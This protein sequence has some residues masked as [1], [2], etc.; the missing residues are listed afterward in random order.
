VEEPG[1]G[2]ETGTNKYATNHGHP[3]AF[4]NQDQNGG[5]T[6]RKSHG[7]MRTDNQGYTTAMDH[8]HEGGLTEHSLRAGPVRNN[9]S[10]MVPPASINTLQ[11]QPLDQ[12]FHGSAGNTWPPTSGLEY[13]K[14]GHEKPLGGPPAG[15]HYAPG[16]MNTYCPNSAS[17][18]RS[19]DA[20]KGSRLLL[21]EKYDGTTPVQTFCSH[22]ESCALYNRWDERDKLAY[23]RWCLTG[24]AAQI[25]WDSPSE[26]CN[27]RELV[28]KVQGR[29]GNTGLEELGRTELRCRRR[30]RGE[31]LQ[32]LYQ[33]IRAIMAK[34][35]PGHTDGLGETIAKDA[36]LVSLDDAKL[37]LRVREWEPADLDAALRIAMR[38]EA[39]EQVVETQTT[40]PR[41]NRQV[42]NTSIS[43]PTDRR[44]GDLEKQINELRKKLDEKDK[45][46]GRNRA[47]ELARDRD[48]FQRMLLSA[49]M[50]GTAPQNTPV[51]MTNSINTT[52][53][54][55]AYATNTTPVSMAYATNTIPAS[56]SYPVH[57]APAPM[58]FQTNTAPA[59]SWSGPSGNQGRSPGNNNG[60]R[61]GIICYYCHQQAN[62][63]ARNCPHRGIRRENGPPTP[64]MNIPVITGQPAPMIAPVG[65]MGPP[66]THM[67][68]T[69]RALNSTD[70]LGKVYIKAKVNGIEYYCLLDTGCDVSVFP[71][72]TVAESEI[73]TTNQ[74]MV[75]A[76]GTSLELVGETEVW[77]NFGEVSVKVK[78]LVSE[79]VQEIMLGGD[80]LTNNG[81]TWNF[82]NSTLSM[83]SRQ[84]PLYSQI[85]GRWCR[86]VV[87][88]EDTEVP[89]WS[90]STLLGSQH[91]RNA[92]V[93]SEK[94]SENWT[95]DNHHL[96][97]G[98]QV[99]RTLVDLQ[100]G[101]IPVRV[102][103]ISEN[104]VNLPKGTVLSELEE[105]TEVLENPISSETPL[106]T[107]SRGIHV[108]PILDGV[109]DEV[110]GIEKRRLESLLIEYRDIFSQGEYDLGRTH[111]V[112]HHIETGDH[113]PI[114]QSL[115]RQPPLYQKIIQEQTADMLKAGIIR[116]ANSE[117]AANVVLA[118]R[119][120]G[121]LRFCV[122]YRSLNDASRKDSFP[123]P[124]IDQ[125]LDTLVG[126]QW[127]STFD[128]ISGYHQVNM[129]ASSAEK[130]TFI[131]REGAYQYDVLPFGL[132]SAPATFQR[133]INGVL[134]G[135]NFRTCLAYLDDIV[136]FSED[137]ETHFER[138]ALLFDRIREARLKFK[139]SKCHILQ[140]KI[141]FLGYV[142]SRDGLATDP[143]KIRMVDEWRTPANI[144]EVRAFL[145]LTSYYRKF[146]LGFADIATPLHRL[147]GNVKFVWDEPCQKAFETLKGKLTSAPI[148][149]LPSDDLPYVLDTDASDYAMGAVLSQIV[150]GNERVI[151]YASRTFNKAERNYCTTRK[152]LSAVVFFIAYFRQYI[153]GHHFLVR[154]DHAALQW[155]RRTPDPVGQQARWL[156]KLEEYD[157]EVTH[158]PGT[159]HRNADAMS[160]PPCPKS[161]CS[162]ETGV[163]SAAV[164]LP[165]LSR[166]TV[167]NR[168]DTVFLDLNEIKVAQRDDPDLKIVYQALADGKSQPAREEMALE[169]AD[170]KAL[171][172]QWPVLALREGTLCREFTKAQGQKFWQVIIPTPSREAFID[173]VHGVGG[174]E[175]LGLEKTTAKIQ[176]LAYW[177][178]YRKDIKE[179]VKQCNICA[180]YHRGKVPRQMGLRSYL[181]GEPWERISL[182]I[183][184]RHPKSSQG[185]VYILTM[186][187]HFSRYALAFPIK[188]HT[189]PTVCGILMTKV[190]PVF[191]FPLQLLADNG[192]EFNSN[193]QTELQKSM[194]IERLR[195]AP[196]HPQGNGALERFHRTL[197]SLLGK[198][199]DQSQ[200]NWDQLLP[201]L[202]SA[203]NGTKHDTTGYTPNYL[204]MG[205]EQRTPIDLV[206]A[207]THPPTDW[208]SYDAYVAEQQGF[209]RTAY[210]MVREQ[211][212]KCAE[213]R[214]ERYNL[215]VN[216]LRLQ[217]GDWVWRFYPRRFTG[218]SPKWQKFYGG[219]FLV[220][221]CISPT[222]YV[223]QKGAKTPNVVVHVDQLKRYKGDVPPSWIKN[224]TGDDLETPNIHPDRSHQNNP[225]SAPL[226]DKER[227]PEMSAHTHSAIT[228]TE[229]RQIEPVVDPSSKDVRRQGIRVRRPPDKLNL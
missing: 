42:Q 56:M 214:K 181:A 132:A 16:G 229:A 44:V 207:D 72:D 120:D 211:T 41:N 149:V 8:N 143:E 3:A 141:S 228:P 154:T 36:F 96:G 27:Y 35:Y 202:M 31:T 189:A 73:K 204:L 184:G 100:H 165:L 134:Q 146:I 79:R 67:A 147:T 168:T 197:N 60:T 193:M 104:V 101:I 12:G 226:M 61:A 218:R 208:G 94:S 20:L 194:G 5:D 43:S 37:E 69:N 29:F 156:E 177:V 108:Q 86:R 51:P 159:Q 123:L 81:A 192:P 182:D 114:R 6:N 49:K 195:I 7:N 166:R 131:T 140:S 180:Q 54:P 50:V 135:L 91:Y 164:A 190:F 66:T 77:C 34:A 152:E 122:D 151:A 30:K 163:A 52:S 172:Y 121:K 62:H 76:N 219:P 18:E 216:E 15:L 19:H 23:L 80:F 227:A 111:L 107:D 110:T 178:G 169:S 167:V 175:H 26:T 186:I 126:S 213:R 137:L 153:L 128:L 92:G 148:L 99:A 224:Q 206:L 78:G 14:I 173:M 223:I 58:V 185:N 199:V 124:R 161:C 33:S 48:D 209:L 188:D 22:F 210:R 118:K 187:D 155:L 183:T 205:R 65:P 24:N 150:D 28:Q 83:H 125:C 4:S 9:L 171:W 136:V 145:G 212:K 90:E 82:A 57:T 138:L 203:Y 217:V 119:K 45:A 116:P 160:R 106:E 201:Y 70:E 98:L 59:T 221:H 93:L 88:R 113:P 117:W 225:V 157:F 176:D 75:A 129:E 47:L 25:L 87:L 13:G 39:Y 222:N 40:G 127:F 64:L 68:S 85:P 74:R 109:D 112:E 38:L 162:P 105:A 53:V 95:T 1:E 32:S 63:I 170:A 84:Y 142:V 220:I 144:H 158:R 97:Q 102:L 89:A 200:R 139:A 174:C 130:T 46:D 11:R 55:M 103:N 133:L 21:P 115:R 179:S 2:L 215:K 191:G 71:R 10:G 196:Y 17:P 198:A